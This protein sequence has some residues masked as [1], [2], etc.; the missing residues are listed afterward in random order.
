MIDD[1]KLTETDLGNNFFVDAASLGKVI[2]SFVLF[3]RRQNQLVFDLQPRAEVVT[4]FLLEMNPDVN[5]HSLN[6]VF[7]CVNRF[8]S[9]SDRSDRV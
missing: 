2:C 4:S 3:F 6:K 5:G 9:Q 1:A 8:E 7:S